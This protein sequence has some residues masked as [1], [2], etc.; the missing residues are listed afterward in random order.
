MKLDFFQRQKSFAGRYILFQW[1]YLGKVEE[2]MY[3]RFH[4]EST[5]RDITLEI[6]LTQSIVWVCVGRMCVTMNR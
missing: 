1:P 6:S 2:T 4:E 3:N 5:E